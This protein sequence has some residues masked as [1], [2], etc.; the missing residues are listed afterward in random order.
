MR[1][2]KITLVACGLV[3]ASAPA[4][5]QAG[6]PDSLQFIKAVKERDGNTATQLISDHPTIVNAKDGSGDTGLIVA[7]RNGDSEWTD[8]LLYKGADVN[9]PGAGGDTPLIAAARVSFDDGADTLIRLA[10]KVDAANKSGETP[11]IVAV[12]QRDSRLV[13]LLLE[14]GADPDRTDFAGYSARDY[15]ARDTRSRDLL[16]LINDKKPKK[17]GL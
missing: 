4:F 14:H 17:T 12:Q 15:A 7:V 11:L 13:R 16:R 2:L 1:M 5:G 8:F 9:M 3:L 10:A 6:A